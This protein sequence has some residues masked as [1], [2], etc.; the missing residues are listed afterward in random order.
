MIDLYKFM[1]LLVCLNFLIINPTFSQIEKELNPP[2]YINTV[3]FTTNQENYSTN[4][5]IIKLGERFTLDFDVLNNEEADYYYTI[6]QLNFDW[7]KSQLIKSEY[8]RG[9]D[10]IK[11]QNYKTSFNTYQTYSHYKLE[12]PNQNVRIIKSG[13]YILKIYDEYENIVFSRKFIVYESITT[14]STRI[15][16]LRNLKYIHTKQSVNFEVNPVTI[17]LNNPKN[18]VKTLI[19]QNN[20]L[21]T[22]ISNLKAQ[23]T[24]GSKLIFKYDEESSFW[25]GNEYLFF[26]NKEIRSSNLNIRTFNLYEIYHN[27]LFTDYP[28][29][30]NSYT[31]NPDINGGFLTTALNADD[32]DIEADYVNIHFSLKNSTNR[33]GES[34]YI[35]GAFNNYSIQPK[36]K[37][38]YNRSSDSYQLMLKLKQGF[39]NYKFVLV[40]EYD[41][42]NQGGVSGNYDETENDY[43]VLIYYRG[44]GYR[45]DRII[46]MGQTSSINITN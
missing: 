29:F 33:P 23:Y 15:K 22:S 37:M 13:N 46:G 10:N 27:Y 43:K 7:S 31:Y 1:F 11:I 17:Q 35:V 2:E 18:T 42:I 45:Y 40:N 39:Y 34:I 26:E 4:L 28:R 24:I 8:L 9:F 32:I 36:Y 19:I 21:S 5:P 20:N 6:D 3:S 30:N 44:Y 14:V 12:I 41:E 25:G 16:R 38:T